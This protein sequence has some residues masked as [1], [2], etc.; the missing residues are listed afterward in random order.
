[1][2]LVVNARDAMPSGGSV[3]IHTSEIHFYTDTEIERARISKGS[4]VEIKVQDTGLG[5]EAKNL[6]HIFDPFFTTKDVGEGTGLG[7]STVYGIIKQTGGF[8]FADS[9]VGAGTIFRILLPAT[10]HVKGPIKQETHSVS[11]LPDTLKGITALLVEDEVAV[12]SFAARALAMQDI[13]VF[14]AGSAEDALLLLNDPDMKIDVI[15]SDVVMPGQD[16]PTW[17]QIALKE[18]PDVKVIFVSGYAEETFSMEFD[19]ITG[20]RFLPKPFTL[21]KLV[22]TVHD[23]CS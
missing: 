19:K 17:V 21:S 15:I 8:I 10:E 2:N 4:Y 14:E 22:Q 5:I 6:S 3:D 7:L 11:L 1:M 12:R 23:M 13:K 20:A 18:R 9:T 16:G